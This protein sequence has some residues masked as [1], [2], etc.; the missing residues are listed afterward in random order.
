[1]GILRRESQHR[2]RR[3]IGQGRAQAGEGGPRDE[4]SV[5]ERDHHVVGACLQGLAGGQNRMGG[6]EALHLRMDRGSGCGPRDLGGH[7]LLPRLN[8]HGDAGRPGLASGGENMAEHGPPG[9][10]V[11]HLGQVGPH[12]RALTGGEHD[13][14]EAASA[15][16][17][18]L[19]RMGGL[20]RHRRSAAVG[21]GAGS[22][23]I[24][25]RYC[26]ACRVA[27]LRGR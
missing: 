25:L 24:R 19:G 20:R 6:A 23:P 5:A 10:R 12:P 8:H 22:R 13:G 2:H 1:M 9:H 16:P 14:R 3:P 7:R 27:S 26:V 21:P 17:G 18:G 15:R 11:Q 4:G